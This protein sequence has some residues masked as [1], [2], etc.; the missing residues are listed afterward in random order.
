MDERLLRDFN[1]FSRKHLANALNELL[2]KS[3]IPVIIRKSAIACDKP[4]NQITK[5][6]RFRLLSLLTAFP[7]QISR[8]R[9][10]KEAIVTAGGVS[11]K[12]L[13][14]KDMSSKLVKGLFF[15]GEVI[16]VDGYTGGYNLQ[17]ALSTGYLAGI[18]AAK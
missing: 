10:L 12:E 18:G 7:V 16:D 4:V 1:K 2:P 17:A 13:S 15:A 8:P 14:P 6:E 3:L 5:E 11:V 9:P